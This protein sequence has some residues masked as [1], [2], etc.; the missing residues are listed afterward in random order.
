[1]RDPGE[2][3]EEGRERLELRV[4]NGEVRGKGNIK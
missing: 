2:K 3:S 4:K 1:M